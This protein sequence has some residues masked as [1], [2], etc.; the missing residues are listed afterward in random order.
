MKELPEWKERMK[1]II[2][3]I[4][5]KLSCEKIKNDLS[6]V[7]TQTQTILYCRESS[8][9]AIEVIEQCEKECD[10]VLFTGRGPFT[11]VDQR[12]PIHIPYEYIPKGVASLTKILWDMQKLGFCLN[13]FSIDVAEPNVIEDAFCD[14]EINP[15]HI[16]SFPFDSYNEEDY[17]HWHLDLWKKNKID[18][19]L[20]GFVW[21][22]DYFKKQNYPVFHLPTMRS[23]VRDAFSQL[24]NRFALKKA[25]YSK[26]AV[27]ILRI[28]VASEN[29]ENYYSNMIQK[30]KAESYIIAYAQ[31]LQ[32]SFFS[33]GRN[34][35]VIFANKG[36][37]KSE[38]N[39]KLL[40]Q[41]QHQIA[42]VGFRLNTGIGTALT[43][44]QSESNARK[45]L[46]HSLQS[47][48]NYSFWV[49]EHDNLIGPLGQKQ[50]LEYGLIS[51]D[52]HTLQIAEKIGMSTT[53][54]TKLQSIIHVR[55]SAVFNIQQLADCLQI[56]PRSARRI[57]TRLL[58]CGFANLY[59]KES[60]AGAGRPKSLY[61]IHLS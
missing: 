4:G 7:S 24:E 36:N 46:Q 31:E 10:A 19:I 23:A 2:G 53:S 1:M 39:Y 3:I 33:Y 16:Y 18:V 25:H 35:Y 50:S 27:E 51:S 28:A 20:T 61:E 32:A 55:K 44:Y 56:T 41:L 58:D 48:E 54:V 22:Y 26:I 59:A 52:V 60:N 45:A 57:V 17:I 40:Y 47:K 38:E 49:D 6:S 9:D 12:Y 13:R 42:L 14:L 8:V 29:S 5:P 30:T 34:E 37:T 21:I 15:S 43:A 11:S